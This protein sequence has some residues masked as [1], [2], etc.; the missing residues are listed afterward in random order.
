MGHRS[1]ECRDKN[2][3]LQGQVGKRANV[4]YQGK[5]KQKVDHYQEFPSCPSCGKRHKGECRAG[6]NVCFRCGKPGHHFRDCRV[7]DPNLQGAPKGQVSPNAQGGQAQAKGGQVQA[8]GGQVQ[9]N[10][11]FYALHR[12]QEVEETPDVVAGMLQVFNLMCILF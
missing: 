7:R 6:M 1:K 9:R 8:K 3:H 5:G 11:R 12:R 4:P 10:N 2:I